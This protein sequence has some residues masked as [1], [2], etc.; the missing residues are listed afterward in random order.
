M[1][2]HDAQENALGGREAGELQADEPA[3]ESPRQEL[4][5]LGET[6]ESARLQQVEHGAGDVGRRASR[7]QP[8]EGHLKTPPINVAQQSHRDETGK[9]APNCPPTYDAI[10]R[11]VA[12]CG[13]RSNSREFALPSAAELTRTYVNRRYV[14]A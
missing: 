4:Q 7:E 3:G 9:I 11:W 8:H 14:R 10:T 2:T 13:A 5:I 1:S 12:N 6:A